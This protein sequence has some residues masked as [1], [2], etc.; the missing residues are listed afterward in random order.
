MLQ[1]CRSETNIE[2]VQMVVQDGL[3][4]QAHMEDGRRH[5]NGVGRG[6]L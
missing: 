6:L 1:L 4:S 3:G 5:K 2:A